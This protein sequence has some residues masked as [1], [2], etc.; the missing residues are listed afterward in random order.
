MLIDILKIHYFSI[1]NSRH[2]FPN[3]IANIDF[4]LT[5]ECLLEILNRMFASREIQ[6]F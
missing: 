5:I 1:A 6:P 2:D 3:K 4:S